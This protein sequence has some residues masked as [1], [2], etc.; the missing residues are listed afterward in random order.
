MGWFGGDSNKSPDIGSGN[1]SS[2]SDY[3]SSSLSDSSSFGSSSFDSGSSS[4]GSSSLGSSSYGSS[5][6]GSSLGDS[7]S[8]SFG[9]GND[10]AAATELVSYIQEQQQQ[11]QLQ[12]NISEMTDLCWDTCMGA[13]DKTLSSRAETCVSNCVD[14]FIDVSL[15]I[16]K[17]LAG[18]AGKM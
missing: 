13:P 1:S 12:A 15:F 8:P 2:Y 17:R 9:S 6:F 18:Q 4:F 3:S 10:E 5:G 7:S 11:Q 16:T 14:R